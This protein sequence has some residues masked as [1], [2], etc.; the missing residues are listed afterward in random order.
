MRPSGRSGPSY[1]VEIESAEG[2][3]SVEEAPRPT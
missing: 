3:S 2:G 1:F